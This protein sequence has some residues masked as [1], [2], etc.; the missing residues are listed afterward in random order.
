LRVQHW[1][2][3]AFIAERFRHGRVLLAGDAAHAIPPS[4]GM[5][6]N[7]GIADVHNLC[8]K[9]AGVLRG[10]AGPDL[11]DS[12]D[13]ERQPVAHLTLRQA[14]ANTQLSM[15]AMAGRR[16]QLESGDVAG[17]VEL[18]W[19]DRYFAQLG[20]V[21]GVRYSSGAVLTGGVST[22]AV[23]T[24]AL[25]TGAVLTDDSAPPEPSDPGTDYV[26]TPA[27]GHRMPHAW[28]APG[29]STLDAIG[30]WFTLFTPD[31][32]HWEQHATA[33]WPLRVETLPDSLAEFFGLGP[34]GALLVRPDG[35]IGAHWPDRPASESVL[36]EALATITG[37]AAQDA[38]A[39]VR[40]GA[41]GQGRP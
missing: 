6:M 38:A 36:A 41:A 11:L 14:V 35:H 24:G 26:P 34:H 5:G 37:S 17:E 40:A 3:N 19:S 23:L 21:L 2:I 15:Q 12:Y 10:W 29:R 25:L 7:V 27:P 1:V 28:L 30:E 33:P 39:T 13:T 4:G 20:L 8:W 18:P 22:D 31:P 32:D 16:A 9:L